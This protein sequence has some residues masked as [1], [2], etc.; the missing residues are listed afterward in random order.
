MFFLAFEV[1]LDNFGQNM[2]H[3]SLTFRLNKKDETNIPIIQCIFKVSYLTFNIIHNNSAI[4]LNL[5]H[6][7][8]LM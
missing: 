3:H 4:C 7:E 2:M 1:S 8:A 6:Q 5:Q